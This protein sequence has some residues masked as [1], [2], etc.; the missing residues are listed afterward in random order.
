MVNQIDV[1]AVPDELTTVGCMKIKELGQEIDLRFLMDP[2]FRGKLISVT[3]NVQNSDEKTVITADNAEQWAYFKQVGSRPEIVVNSTWIGTLGLTK[4]VTVLRI[5]FE[6]DTFRFNPVWY[7]YLYLKEPYGDLNP[8][9]A[10]PKKSDPEPEPTPPGP[11]PPGPTPGTGDPVT[12]EM[13][14]D[15][16]TMYFEYVAVNSDDDDDN[17]NDNG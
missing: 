6:F 8:P 1:K 10:V 14:E 9:Y 17:N 16:E 4:K 11:T 2:D 15:N 3:W 13:A 5:K 7:A 12:V